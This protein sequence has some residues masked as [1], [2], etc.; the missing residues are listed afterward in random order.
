MKPAI[1]FEEKI[2]KTVGRRRMPGDP[3]AYGMALQKNGIELSK[4]LGLR[5]IPRGVFRFRSHE[6]ADAWLMKQ[7]TRKPRN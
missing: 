5:G 2:G 6:E 4:S 7:L 1:N 3:F